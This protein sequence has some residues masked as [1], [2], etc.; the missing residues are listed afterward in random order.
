MKKLLLVLVSLFCLLPAHIFMMFFVYF[1]ASVTGFLELGYFIGCAIFGALAAVP[2]MYLIF[3]NGNWGK[4]KKIFL[5]VL[6]GL[7][8]GVILALSSVQVTVPGKV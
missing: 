3:Q 4:G 2:V 6:V 7:V 5:S 8:Y 1:F